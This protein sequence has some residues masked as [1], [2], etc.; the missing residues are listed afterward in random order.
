M[1]F[2]VYFTEVYA[3]DRNNIRLPLTGS[4]VPTATS[5]KIF[6]YPALNQAG[7][8]INDSL[9]INGN[10]SK[11]CTRPLLVSGFANK[12]LLPSALIKSLPLA[13]AHEEA[14]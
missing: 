11:K 14:I 12:G 4:G 9:V 1:P 3:I 8:T 7:Q 2:G 10:N 13:R 5:P 6:K